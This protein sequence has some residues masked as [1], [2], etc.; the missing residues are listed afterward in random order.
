MTDANGQSSTGDATEGSTD[1]G[2]GVLGSLTIRSVAKYAGIAVLVLGV[3]VGAGF[4]LGFVGVPSVEAV[5]NRFDSVNDSTTTID[6]KLVVNNPNPIGVSLGD[7]SVDYTVFMNDVPMANGSKHG[8]SIG[9]GN[10]SV[11]FESYMNNENIPKWWYTH[12]SNGETTEVLV[13]ADVSV[14]LLGGKSI[15]LPQRQT[16]ETDIIGQFNDTTT[17]E[18]NAGVPLVSDPVLYVNETR[19]TYGSNVTLERTPLDMAFTV[20]NPKSYPYTVSE[21]GYEIRMNDIT[22]GEGSTERSYTI[23]GHTERTLETTTVIKNGNLD[24]WWVSHL[25]RDQVTNL[26]ID[27]YFLID[28]GTGEPIRIDSQKL[29]HHTVIETDIFGTKDSDGLEPGTSDDTASGEDSDGSSGEDSTPTATSD[30][31]DD[32]TSTA[33]ATPTPTPTATEDD[34]II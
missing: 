11:E 12:V 33:T 26:T 32:G 19:A 24:D 29:D 27:F 8:L 6:T 30:S 15:S 23:P 34:G 1:G 22:V 2:A 16:I 5:E 13:D 18:V 25:E 31:S 28:T 20:Y 7:T 14:G 10:S 3:L 21:V 4:L 17:R 9:T